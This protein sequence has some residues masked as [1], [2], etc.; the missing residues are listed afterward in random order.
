MK[1][2]SLCVRT[3]RDVFHL[4]LRWELVDPQTLTEKSHWIHMWPT[5]VHMWPTCAVPISHA[6]PYVKNIFTCETHVMPWNHIVVWSTCD[7]HQ[8]TC[9]YTFGSFGLLSLCITLT[10]GMNMWNWNNTRNPHVHFMWFFRKAGKAIR[11]IAAAEWRLRLIACVIAQC[12][13]WSFW[14]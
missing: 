2:C 14:I 11:P 7:R 9:D 5:C 3:I 4:G 13:W 8:L 1:F 10:C 12:A 6:Y